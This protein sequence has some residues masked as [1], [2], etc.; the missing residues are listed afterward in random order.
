M[1]ITVLVLYF[2]LCLPPAQLNYRQEEADWSRD[3]RGSAL[4]SA[5]NLSNYVIYCTKRDAGTAKEFYETLNKV[6]PPM[7]IRLGSP[8]VRQLEND[9]TDSF[10]NALGA[11]LQPGH[12]VQ[13][14]SVVEGELVDGRVVLYTARLSDIYEV[15][16][17][18]SVFIVV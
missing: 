15:C 8:K 16:Y 11:D 17:E 3:M 2:T 10:L 5:V 14:V 18:W 7:G 13:M 12:T 4:I 9:R 1:F 6:C